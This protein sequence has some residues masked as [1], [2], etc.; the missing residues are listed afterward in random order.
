MGSV[1]YKT[2]CKKNTKMKFLYPLTCL[3]ATLAIVK[4]E[5][6]SIDHV[7]CASGNCQEVTYTIDDGYKVA[8]CSIIIDANAESSMP[9]IEKPTCLNLND[10]VGKVVKKWNEWDGFIHPL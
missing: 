5:I 6:I 7:K 9:I 8:M 3:F 4:S 2:P 10:N 1:S